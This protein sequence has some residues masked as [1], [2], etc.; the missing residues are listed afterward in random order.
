MDEATSALDT[1][2]EKVVQEALDRMCNGMHVLLHFRQ[3]FQYVLG[4]TTIVIAH[5]LSTIRN[6]HRIYVFANGTV[7]EQGTHDTLMCQEGSKYREMV[8]AQMIDEINYDNSGQDLNRAPIDEA[9]NEQQTCTKIN[10]L[11][12]VYHLLFYHSRKHSSSSKRSNYP[13]RSG[14]RLVCGAVNSFYNSFFLNR[15]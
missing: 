10:T 15:L 1:S 2:G 4:R 3:W 8:R 11:F 7:V 6:A 5:R 14:E 12:V 9:D 13:C